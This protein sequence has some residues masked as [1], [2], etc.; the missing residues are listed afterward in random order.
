MPGIRR[1]G[2]SHVCSCFVPQFPF[3]PLC[4]SEMAEGVLQNK[5]PEQSLSADDG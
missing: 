2:L 5:G 4:L 3:L 1:V